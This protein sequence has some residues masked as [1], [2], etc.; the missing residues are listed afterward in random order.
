MGRAVGITQFL[1]DSVGL[2]MPPLIGLILDLAGF[3]MVG[4]LL[5]VMSALALVWGVRV[6]REVN[7]STRP[8]LPHQNQSP[9]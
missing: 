2:A 6:I 9:N 3:S 7:P 8:D 4:V 1:V 5:A